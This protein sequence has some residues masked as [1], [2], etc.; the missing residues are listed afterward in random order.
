MALRAA[1]VGLAAVLLAASQDSVPLAAL[2]ADSECPAGGAPCA[3]NALQRRAQ[4]SGSKADG[5]AKDEAAVAPQEDEEDVLADPNEADEE[6]EEEQAEAQISAIE[7]GSEDE[8]DFFADAAAPPPPPPGGQQPAAPPSVASAATASSPGQS[9]AFA[10]IVP[11]PDP[12]EGHPEAHVPVQQQLQVPRREDLRIEVLDVFPEGRP[13]A[14]PYPG[15][16]QDHDGRHLQAL[17][18]REDPR[19]Q[20]GRAVRQGQVPVQARPLLQRP[21][22]RR[23]L[24]ANVAGRTAVW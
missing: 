15:R 21:Q 19:R 12:E 17:R 24:S 11:M 7:E 4:G 18:L 1:L 13:L 20:S 6:E 5:E 3:L 9:G 10:P 16:L 14:V 23:T 8:E 2:E 22:V